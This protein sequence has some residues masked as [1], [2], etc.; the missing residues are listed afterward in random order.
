[1]NNNNRD[2]NIRGKATKYTEHNVKT[3]LIIR[4]TEN[5]TNLENVT[6]NVKDTRRQERLVES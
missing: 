4:K 3:T 1:M 6:I 2:N 5:L